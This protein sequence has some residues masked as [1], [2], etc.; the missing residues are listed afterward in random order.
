[1]QNILIAS[2]LLYTKLKAEPFIVSNLYIENS[3]RNLALGTM[4]NRTR[5]MSTLDQ[6]RGE[7]H[8]SNDSVSV[9]FAADKTSV[10]S[11]VLDMEHPKQPRALT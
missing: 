4:V 11:K 9:N 8:R 5:L 2:W 7:L 6:H 3:L 10:C 1:M